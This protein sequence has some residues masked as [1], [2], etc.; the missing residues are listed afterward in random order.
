MLRRMG[1]E[2][3]PQYFHL[4]KTQKQ[5]DKET[6]VAFAIAS[7]WG[8]ETDAWCARAGSASTGRGFPPRPRGD[9]IFA[10][11]KHSF[12]KYDYYAIFSLLQTSIVLFHWGHDSTALRC[13]GNYTDK[14]KFTI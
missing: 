13:K 4:N 6:N 2:V 1:N 5:K 7:A 12:I 9:S 11:C 8:L 10:C 14:L 3:C